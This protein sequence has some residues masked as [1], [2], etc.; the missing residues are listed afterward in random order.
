MLVPG[1][2]KKKLPVCHR[3]GRGVSWCLEGDHLRATADAAAGC[4]QN[5]ARITQ[6]DLLKQK[7]NRLIFRLCGRGSGAGFPS[8]LVKSFPMHNLKQRL[9]SYR[10]YGPREAA[11]LLE[12]AARNIPVPCVYGYGIVTGGA[13][14][15]STAV[16]MEDLG[17]NRAIGTL[18]AAPGLSEDEKMGIL[19]RAGNLLIRLFE[20]RCNHIDL[21]AQSMHLGP[22][23][24]DDRLID[25]HYSVFLKKP[26]L[27]V[28]LFHLAYFS[29]ALGTAVSD[30]MCEAWVRKTLT[31]LQVH[32]HDKN[33]EIFRLLRHRSFSRKERSELA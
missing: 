20:G 25:F 7:R 28:L 26:S 18:L 29:D 10:R 2:I 8:V 6:N 4:M 9:Y 5:P 21:N 12:A 3:R 15:S 13:T 24:T 19:N 22:S 14:V 30:D 17:D 32:N 23:P 31:D 11:N 16:M 27:S 33:L 1:S